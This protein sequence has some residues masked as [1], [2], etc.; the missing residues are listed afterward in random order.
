MQRL[1]LISIA[2]TIGAATSPAL[3]P[4][5]AQ[6]IQHPH[7]MIVVEKGLPG[8]TLYDADTD[9]PICDA[10]SGAMSP[11]EA[12]FSPNGR[13]VYLP[14]YG[15]TNIGVPGTNEH[16]I[17]FFSTSDCK[18]V[19]SL[20]TGE[21]LR[22][23]GA[24]AGGSGTLYVTSELAQSILLIDP[25]QRKIVAAIPTGSRWTHMLAVT[26]DEKRAFASNTRSKTISVLDI[27]DRKIL[28][29][30]ATTSANH[31]LAI[32]PDGKWFVT[33]LEEG[34]V[35]FYR[36]SDDSLDF[37]VPVDGWA[38]VGKFAADG[39]YYEM[40]SGSPHTSKSWGTGP[41]RVWKIYPKTRKVMLAATDDLGAGTGSLAINPFNHE[42]YVSAMVNNQ[43]DVIDP[44]TLRVLKRLPTQKTPDCIE[45]AAVQ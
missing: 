26:S 45:F 21:Y 2:I 29:T 33:S 7:L 12:A 43:I 22:P 31:R 41:V 24:W 40:G 5:F 20:E 36:A 42:I 25:R 3:P 44:I 13:I 30:I 37:S 15:S 1:L 27:P 14:I 19:G 23:H 16:A 28:K 11:H 32:S 34:K 8:A 4:P 6:A 35:L 39:L 17:E 10:K 9:Q 38:F 18:K